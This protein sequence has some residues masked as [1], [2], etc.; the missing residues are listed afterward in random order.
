MIL[1]IDRTSF[2]Q[3][4]DQIYLGSH[5]CSDDDYH[6]L[7]AHGI[8]AAIDMREEGTDLWHF[9]AFL[10]LPTVDHTAST[11]LHLKLGIAFLRECEKERVPVFVHCTAGVGRSA[12]LVLAHLLS[13]AYREPGT[14]AALEYIRARRSVIHPNPA[15]IRAAE[16]AAREY[17]SS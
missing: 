15:Q 5:I 8:R 14:S 13:D 9:E 17:A 3:I 4:T 12:A 11:T 16:Q 2:D 1:S 10:W 7:R 6:K